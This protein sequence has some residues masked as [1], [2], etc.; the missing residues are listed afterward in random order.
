MITLHL[1]VG[2]ANGVALDVLRGADSPVHYRSYDTVSLTF[3]ADKTCTRVAIGYL[4][5]SRNMEIV[6]CTLGG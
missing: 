2:V 6:F 3:Y 5:L 4:R 1:Q